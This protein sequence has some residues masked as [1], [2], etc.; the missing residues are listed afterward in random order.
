MTRLHRLV[1]VLIGSSALSSGCVGAADTT[2]PLIDHDVQGQWHE[3]G[4]FPGSA[5]DIG[6]T[7]TAG[8][9]T[10]TGTFAREAGAGGTLTA[11]GSVRHDSLHL[12]VVFIFDPR[13]TAVQPDTALFEGLLVARDT[14]SGTLTRAG[15]AESL[16][17]V[18]LR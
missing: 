3:P 5:F 13:F 8:A 14:I 11:F 6:L 9:L 15:F 10:G 4:L 17:L 7:E 12:Q 18:R 2:G 16:Q 1:A